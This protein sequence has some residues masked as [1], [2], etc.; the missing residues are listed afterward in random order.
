M[1]AE[2]ADFEQYLNA[3]AKQLEAAAD[4]VHHSYRVM[5]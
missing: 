5:S 3:Y 1:T 4:G 2:A